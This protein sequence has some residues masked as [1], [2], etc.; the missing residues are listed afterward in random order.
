VGTSQGAELFSSSLFL[1]DIAVHHMLMRIAPGAE[2]MLR[3]LMHEE[4]A[5]VKCTCLQHFRA[6]SCIVPAGKTG[7]T[8]IH[9]KQHCGA[10]AR[11]TRTA[12]A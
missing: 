5:N 3:F 11:F 1:L 2:L 7:C 9:S 10:S 12:A 8:G 6:L 4:L